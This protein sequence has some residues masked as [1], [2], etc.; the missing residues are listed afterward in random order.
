MASEESDAD[1][2][3]YSDIEFKEEVGGGVCG[4]VHRVTFKKPYKGHT[5]AAA[6]NFTDLTPQEFKILSKLNHP[7]IIM[8]LG[9]FQ[10]GPINLIFLEYTPFGSL[11]D[12]LTQDPFNA[13]PENLLRKW[14][15]ESA[16]AVE[17]LHD[18]HVLHRDLKVKN[19]L[20]FGEDLLLKLSDF[21][22]ACDTTHTH[23]FSS[24]MGTFPYMAPEVVSPRGF[25]EQVE[26]SIYSDIYAYGMLLLEICTKRPPFE[27]WDWRQITWTVSKWPG[28]KP[29]IPKDC[30]SDLADLIL[31]CLRWTPKDRPTIKE[32][33]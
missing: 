27:G 32:G 1:T 5:E 7:H 2:L 21:G 13:T 12:Y 18:N 26:Y 8:L 17:Y 31:E 23:T 20:L 11:H 33:K 14:A 4:K 10:N 15:R 28:H 6:K 19:C 25:R 9:K 24:I 3:V 30:P 29:D 16:L 22:L